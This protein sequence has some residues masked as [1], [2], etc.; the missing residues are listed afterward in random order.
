MGSIRDAGQW[1]G[2]IA[3]ETAKYRGMN[4]SSVVLVLGIVLA[5]R[6]IRNRRIA[7]PR[8]AA[9]SL[10]LTSRIFRRRFTY[11]G[12]RRFGRSLTGSLSR[13]RR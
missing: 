5:P 2:T 12:L 6:P 1:P 11:V 10:T 4:G 9:D 3:R 13:P 8:A 7:R